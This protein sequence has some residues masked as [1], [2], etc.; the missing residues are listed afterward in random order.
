M[1][2]P[3]GILHFQYTGSIY[4]IW[5]IEC[6]EGPFCWFSGALSPRWKRLN[7]FEAISQGCYDIINR[8]TNREYR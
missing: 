7:S 2:L 6:L 3:F 8:N 1:K 5:K 4:I